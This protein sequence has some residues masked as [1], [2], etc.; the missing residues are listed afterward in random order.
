MCCRFSEFIEQQ[1]SNVSG[2]TCQQNSAVILIAFLLFVH[3]VTSDVSIAVS[4][5]PTEIP[6][7]L[8][9]PWQPV[10]RH[11]WLQYLTL[12]QSRC[13]FLRQQNSRKQT[14]QRFEGNCAFLG[15]LIQWSIHEK[16]QRTKPVPNLR[17]IGDCVENESL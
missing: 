14:M 13:H 8:G 9:P 6:A 10:L 16:I 1:A 7:E 3:L 4:T 17:C 5:E 15:M 2:G 12:S 11:R